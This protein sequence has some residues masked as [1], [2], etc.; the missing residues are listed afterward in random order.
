MRTVWLFLMCL[1]C[2]AAML[3]ARSS[4]R[5]HAEKPI[6]IETEVVQS[7]AAAKADRLEVY[8]PAPQAVLE[9]S[10]GAAPA[11]PERRSSEDI[12]VSW[13]WRHGAKTIT[14][15]SARGETKQLSRSKFR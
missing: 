7:N 15:V 10:I 3:T 11:P 8:R 12:T 4:F 13:H 14:T 5:A 1:I 9:R 6:I 2:I